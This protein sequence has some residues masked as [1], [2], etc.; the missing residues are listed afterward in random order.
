MT[1]ASA[2]VANTMLPAQ[3]TGSPGSTNHV[4]TNPSHAYVASAAATRANSDREPH[5]RWRAN[6]DSRAAS[7][8]SQQIPKTNPAQLSGLA[9]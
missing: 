7:N 6:R 4:S 8:A 1:N 2:T 9:W 5:D 3:R